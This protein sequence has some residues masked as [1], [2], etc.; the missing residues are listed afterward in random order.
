MKNTVLA[1][2]I[3]LGSL[4]SLSAQD[5]T[6]KAWTY[7]LALG[8]DA[9]G[10]LQINPRQGAGQDRL[11]LGGNA[12]FEAKYKKDRTEW[13]NTASWLIG[14]QKLGDI[15]NSDNRFQK[16]TDL[17]I[18]RTNFD[19]SISEGSK[20]GYWAGAELQTQILPTYTGNV[21][22]DTTAAQ[23]GSLTQ[24][25]S[26]ATAVVAP[27]MTYKPNDHLKFR[28]SPA[29]MKLN[30]VMEDRLARLG[31]LGN[32][33]RSVNDYDKVALQIGAFAN[34]NYTNKY[35]KDRIAVTS[36]LNLFTNYL[37]DPQYI[38]VDW[39]TQL[40]FI[41]FKGLSVGLNT[42]VWYDHDFDVTLDKTTGRLGKG[43][44]ITNQLLVKY[45]VIF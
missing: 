45:S 29:S 10:L 35:F 26:P 28:F 15:T 7:K 11:G 30:I 38:D 6:P 8:A 4:G 16:Q 25:M 19:Y 20:F 18:L 32:P 17:F 22:G 13:I 42:I 12:L 9:A 39:N 27:G 34:I 33:W 43:V 14:L 31:T 36:N 24:F 2:I 37:K 44:S 21:L 40:D 41:I 3:G 23:V 1:A 5:T